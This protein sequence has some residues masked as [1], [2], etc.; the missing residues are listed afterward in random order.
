MADKVKWLL[1]GAGIIAEK[2]VG[3]AL[4]DADGSEL[5]GVCDV[6][7]DNARKVAQTCKADEIFTDIDEAI[8]NTQADAIYVATPV[9]LHVPTAIKA[10]EAGKHVL[11]EKPLGLTAADAQKLI[12]VSDAYEKLK[13]ACAYYRRFYPA[14]KQAA[15]MIKAGEFGEINLIRMHYYSWCGFPVDNW[16]VI[17]AKSGGGPLSD[18]GSHMFDVMVGLLGM[19][20]TVYSKVQTKTHDYEVEDSAAIVMSMPGGADVVAS[21]HWNS[22]TWTHEF[23]I[24]GTEAK[25]KWHPFDGGKVVKTVGRDIKEIDLPNA[26]NVHLPLVED[27]VKAIQND[28]EPKVTLQEALKTNVLLDAV[29]ESAATKKEV[30][31]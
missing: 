25:I 31:L 22:K 29:Y 2:R 4:V 15:E 11:I 28:T 23:E 12:E 14:F 21:F 9:Y 26:E 17:K 8:A 10:L 20:K 30:V 24:V 16:R 13:T 7:E 19:P 27:F 5:V 18:M 6:V 1:I 3:P